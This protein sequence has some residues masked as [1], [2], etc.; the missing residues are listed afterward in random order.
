MQISSIALQSLKT[1]Y[2]KPV[3]NKPKNVLAQNNGQYSSTSLP[4]GF[5]TSYKINFTAW[6]NPNRLVGDVDL[7]SYHI[8]TERS[9]ERYRKLYASF[10]ENEE[11]DGN[12]LFDVKSK[13]LPLTSNESMEKFIE[14]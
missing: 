3:D 1:P 6:A 10:S 11:V 14:T 12:K 4:L 8:M 5:N 9:K 7:D 13:K 2:L